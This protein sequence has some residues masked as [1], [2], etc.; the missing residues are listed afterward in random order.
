MPLSLLQWSIDV[1]T[2]GCFLFSCRDGLLPQN[3]GSRYTA[4]ASSDRTT[5][6]LSKTSE[7]LKANSILC[8]FRH[9]FRL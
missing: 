3:G 5:D 9:P 7:L 4:N 6:T 8:D 1:D 2:Q